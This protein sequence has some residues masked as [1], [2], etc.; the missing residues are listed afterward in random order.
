MT[1]RF[2]LRALFGLAVLAVSASCASASPAQNSFS[3]DSPVSEATPIS[4]CALAPLPDRTP[5]IRPTMTPLP[6]QTPVL[7][8]RSQWVDTKFKS[9]LLDRE[10]PILVYLP[11]GYFDSPKYYPTLY[12]LGGFTGDYREWTYWGICETLDRM[13]R[14]GKLQP[15]I[16]VLPEGDHSWWFNHA[17]VA[18]SDGKPWGDYIWKD[19]VGYVDANYRTLPRRNSRAIGG[20]SAGG[21]AALMLALTHPEIFSIA[22]AHSPSVRGAD[23]S[24]PDFGDPAY[25]KQYDP[26]WLIAHT[27]TWRQLTFWID[28]GKD[29]T[30]W[31]DAIFQ[32]HESLDALGV[33]HD[34]QNTW[35]GIH[36]D[37]Y[38]SA[39]L[40]DYLTWYSSKL[41]G[42]AP[43]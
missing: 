13:I 10:L 39:H 43:Q 21:Q 15:M 1:R 9:A 29:D 41:I 28:I 24:V 38:W 2:L 18:G 40:P 22:G 33:P 23:G 32:F 16:V 30:Q 42:E 31:G 26:V 4:P 6:P 27:Q 19:V 7:A 5:V 11:P 8:G 12:M 20:L 17:R 14:A 25:F 34:F 3:P 35:S 37:S 36:D